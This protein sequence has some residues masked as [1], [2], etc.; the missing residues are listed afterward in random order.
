[1]CQS[2]VVAGGPAFSLDPAVPTLCTLNTCTL[3][4]INRGILNQQ[5]A[6]ARF[7]N[8]DRERLLHSRPAVWV[9]H[10]NEE[11]YHAVV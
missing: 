1:M 3:I 10:E 9:L 11:V 8:S 2:R 7:Q 5:Y 6:D 4:R